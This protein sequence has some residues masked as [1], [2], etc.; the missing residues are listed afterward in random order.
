MITAFKK[1]VA[2]VIE[3]DVKDV[4]DVIAV[5]SRRRRALLAFECTVNYKIRTSTESKANA[6]LESMKSDTALDLAL[7]SAMTDCA[8]ECINLTDDR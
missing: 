8:E 7:T 6:A 1:A 5:S 4:Y 3:G 2:A